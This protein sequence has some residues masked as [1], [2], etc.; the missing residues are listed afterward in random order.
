MARWLTTC[1]SSGHWL[2]LERAFVAGR[3]GT[4]CRSSGQF[5]RRA[6]YDLVVSRVIA[7]IRVL[8][9]ACH[10]PPTVGVTVMTAL[11]A[12]AAGHGWGTGTL[13]VAAVFTGQ[14]S[15]GWSNDAYDAERDRIVGRRDKPLVRD[16]W[17]EPVVRRATVVAL[18]A[19]IAL[20]IACGAPAAVVHLVCGV[21]A[22]WLYNIWGKR[23]VWSPVPYAVGFAALPATVWLAL[24]SRALPP[25]WVMVAGA[26]LGVGA[27]LLNALP[28]LADDLATGIVGL[29][30]RLGA[31][32]VRI[33][34]PLVL[35]V[36]TV[37][38]VL[39][40]GNVSMAGVLGWGVLAVC[41][42]LALVTMRTQGRAP[43]LTAM[44]IAGINVLAIVAAP[45]GP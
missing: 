19:C 14:L 20:S 13:V 1:P 6:A 40:P 41:A 29:P 4:R 38:V 35:L 2:S 28:D 8:A 7:V 16:P 39:R 31:P 42:A 10:L 15:I 37:I 30:Q 25:A 22:G 11:L 21:G 32:T 34:A 36:A 27:H 9:L 17:A 12:V 33:A 5:T 18:V 43:F 3:A 23:S 24:P 26:A 44:A 45:P